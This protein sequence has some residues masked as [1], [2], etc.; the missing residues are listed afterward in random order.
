M[1]LDLLPVQPEAE[2]DLPGVA[3]RWRGDLRSRRDDVVLTVEEQS[4]ART[5]IRVVKYIEDLRAEL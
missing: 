5:E 4:P 1:P 3:G 2:L